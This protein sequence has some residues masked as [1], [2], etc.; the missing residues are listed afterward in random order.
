MIFFNGEIPLA[1]K[2]KHFSL[3]TATGISLVDKPFRNQQA[4]GHTTGVREKALRT[5]SDNFQQ[6][7]SVISEWLPFLSGHG[8]IGTYIFI[9]IY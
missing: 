9:S 4:A 1:K 6:A 8:N 7:G 2:I 5:V 3:F